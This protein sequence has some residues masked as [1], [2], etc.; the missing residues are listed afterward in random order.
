ME[1]K[2]QLTQKQIYHRDFYQKKKQTLLAKHQARAK[3]NQRYSMSASLCLARKRAI[4]TIDQDYL[5]A[6]YDQQEG[7][8]ALSGIRMTWSTG[9]TEPT[10]ISMDRI[11][12]NQGYIEGNVRLI[13]Q[14]I[15]AFRGKMN[16]DEL[17]KMAKTLVCAM[18]LKKTA[19]KAIKEAFV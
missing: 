13:C 19:N 1:T 7:I 8:C 12:N 15:N 4:C 3:K 16:D 5:M 17:L 6:L 2:N 14:A 11:D 9:K 18:E 10:S